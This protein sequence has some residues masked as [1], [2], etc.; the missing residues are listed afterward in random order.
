MESDDGCHSTASNIDEGTRPPSEDLAEPRG[1]DPKGMSD[2]EQALPPLAFYAAKHMQEMEQEVQRM[3]SRAHRRRASEDPFETFPLQWPAYQ[4]A[5]AHRLADE[6]RCD[7]FPSSIMTL[8]IEHLY[9]EKGGSQ[10]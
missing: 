7:C 3:L 6:L 9:V 10:R 1:F 2:T 8:M 4:W 5:D